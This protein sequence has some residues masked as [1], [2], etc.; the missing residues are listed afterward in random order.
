MWNFFFLSHQNKIPYSVFFLVLFLQSRQILL[1]LFL[2]HEV[3]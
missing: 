1:I 3:H 2:I